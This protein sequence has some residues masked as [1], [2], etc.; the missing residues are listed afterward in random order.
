MANY[1]DQLFH[2]GVLDGQ[3]DR[4]ALEYS[5]VNLPAFWQQ[6]AREKIGQSFLKN[7]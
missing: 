4:A 5:A 2:F 1:A 3:M 7:R 6:L